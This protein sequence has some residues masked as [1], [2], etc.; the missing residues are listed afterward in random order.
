MNPYRVSK[1]NNWFEERD[2]DSKT[3]R[4]E[5]DFVREYKAWKP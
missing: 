2:S 3:V 1:R 4:V 5:G